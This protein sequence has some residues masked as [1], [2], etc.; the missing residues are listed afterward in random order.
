MNK[1]VFLCKTTGEMNTNE[2][3]SYYWGAQN[4]VLRNF[5]STFFQKVPHGFPMSLS[6]VFGIKR[7]KSINGA[8]A[9]HVL[10]LRVSLAVSSFL[11]LFRKINWYSIYTLLSLRWFSQSSNDGGCNTFYLFDRFR[12]FGA[13]E[14]CEWESCLFFKCHESIVWDWRITSV[15]EQ[16]PIDLCLVTFLVMIVCKV[17][18]V[19]L[20]SL[21]AETNKQTEKKKV[22]E[23]SAFPVSF[24]G[25]DRGA[26]V[27]WPAAGSPGGR[28]RWAQLHW[29]NGLHLLPV[30][31]YLC[32]FFRP[33]PWR[34]RT[35][36]RPAPSPA[37]GRR[38][39]WRPPSPPRAAPPSCT[40]THI[41]TPAS[42]GEGKELATGALQRSIIITLDLM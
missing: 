8:E 35:R 28:R 6:C 31:S 13:E 38:P 29:S 30:V 1:A 25:E 14:H 10:M 26:L 23:T 36:R 12:G 2:P 32:C 37:T 39:W 41:H 3:L 18:C 5:V 40:Q 4:L 11:A 42:V 24:R 21:T 20:N 33:G 22:R 9:R 27:S 7:I 15:A 17:L 16:V 34:Q 19:L